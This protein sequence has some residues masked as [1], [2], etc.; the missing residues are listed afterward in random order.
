MGVMGTARWAWRQLT[1]MGTFPQQL[2]AAARGNRRRRD[3][4]GRTH[5]AVVARPEAVKGAAILG[6]H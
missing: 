5:I 3:G 4:H 6:R 2:I 1:S